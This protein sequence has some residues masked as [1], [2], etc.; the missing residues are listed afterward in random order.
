MA[1]VS[2]WP[3]RITVPVSDEEIDADG[4]LTEAGALRVFAEARQAY[5]SDCASLA[6]LD[7]LV[8]ACAVTLGPAIVRTGVAVATGVVEIFPDSF[9]MHARIRSDDDGDL[10]ADGV[11]DLSTGSDLPIECRDEFIARA[12]RATYTI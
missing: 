6:G 1:I 5:L 9:T 12:H 2:K 10:A 7:V 4:H 8:R 11:C 3:V